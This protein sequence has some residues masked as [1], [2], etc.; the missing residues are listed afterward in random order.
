MSSTAKH[1][2]SLTFRVY[3]CLNHSE[4][5]Q[6]QVTVTVRPA[7]SGMGERYDARYEATYSSNA[8]ELSH[9]HPLGARPGPDCRSPEAIKAAAAKA[10]AAL[11]GAG[12]SPAADTD[13]VIVPV[14]SATTELVKLLTGSD[15]YV[16][17]EAGR[18]FAGV[19]RSDAHQV[20]EA[21]GSYRGIAMRALAEFWD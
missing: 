18:R 16:L 17:E 12:C 8:R 3:N 21:T 9:M 7:M 1:H 5:C 19:D 15:A 4:W 11:A 6:I 13:G 2:S 10:R 14:N 20:A